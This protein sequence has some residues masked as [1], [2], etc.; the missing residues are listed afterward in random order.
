MIERPTSAQMRA[1]PAATFATVA[2]IEL[3]ND[4]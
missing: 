2:L 3:E 4:R 1:S